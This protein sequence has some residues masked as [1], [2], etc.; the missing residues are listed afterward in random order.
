VHDV[1]RARTSIETRELLCD[2][3]EKEWAVGRRCPLDENKLVGNASSRE[4][5]VIELERTEEPGGKIAAVA[6][7]AASQDD[8]E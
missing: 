5:V 2:F 3:V 7:I 6:V 1:P 8:G 4:L